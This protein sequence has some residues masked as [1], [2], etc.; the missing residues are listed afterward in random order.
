LRN[1]LDTQMAHPPGTAMAALFS[2]GVKPPVVSHRAPPPPAARIYLVEV[3]NGSK[4][5]EEK[6][7]AGEGKQ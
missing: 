3:F 2:D 5:T 7:A 1:P 4:K 6:F